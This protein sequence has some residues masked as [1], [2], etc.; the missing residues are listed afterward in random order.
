MEFER[1]NTRKVGMVTR[2]RQL[3]IVSFTNVRIRDSIDSQGAAYFDD[4]EVEEQED[5]MDG[6]D[7]VD[8]T[9]ILEGLQV[10]REVD[11]L[12]N[13]LRFGNIYRRFSSLQKSH[14]M[15]V[16]GSVFLGTKNILTGLSWNLSVK[17]RI[18]NIIWGHR[19]PFLSR[20]PPYT[21]GLHHPNMGIE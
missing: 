5:E 2:I 4:D 20:N 16:L 19:I 9:P 21:K 8:I 12:A 7:E 6:D 17:N 18:T 13:P 1:L 11:E 3:I 14:D 10:A 15:D